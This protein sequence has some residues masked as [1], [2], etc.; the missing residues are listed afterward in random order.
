MTE[1]RSPSIRGLLI[2]AVVAVGVALGIHRVW[3][4]SP[5][6]AATVPPVDLEALIAFYRKGVAR[7]PEDFRYHALLAG[8]L[9]ERA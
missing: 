5:P 7:D 1:G 4:A 6:H 2:T 3:N 9:I 8:A